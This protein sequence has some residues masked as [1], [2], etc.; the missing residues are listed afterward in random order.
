VSDV[1]RT[2][3]GTTALAAGAFVTSR[4]ECDSAAAAA[5]CPTEPAAPPPD[6]A[7]QRVTLNDRTG[8]PMDLAVLPNGDVLHTTRKGLIWRHSARTDVDIVVG[9]EAPVVTLVQPTK[10]QAFQFGATVTYEVTV[11]DDQDVDSGKVRVTYVLGH[12]H[13]H[14]RTTAGGCIGSIRRRSRPATTRPTAGADRH[15]RGRPH[16]GRLTA[17]R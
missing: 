2:L 3:S 14:P 12:D 11:T 16:P 8:E 13:G 17:R 5:P 1:R 7:F 9:T 15:R 4:T 10:G 6:D